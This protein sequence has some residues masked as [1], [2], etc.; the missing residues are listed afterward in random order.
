MFKML[1]VSSPFFFKSLM[2]NNNL[3]FSFCRVNIFIYRDSV[4]LNTCNIYFQIKY[5]H[6]CFYIFYRHIY[7]Y[8]FLICRCFACLLYKYVFNITCLYLI[9]YMQ[10][11]I[12]KI[13]NP[14]HS[15]FDCCI[16]SSNIVSSIVR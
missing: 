15:S 8:I 11:C 2:K 5:I 10:F 4:E 9:F 16:T 7:I 14:I 12:I 3:F 6:L 1:L 13:I